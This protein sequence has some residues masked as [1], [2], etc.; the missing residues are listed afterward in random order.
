[1]TESVGQVVVD[2]AAL[3][4]SDPLACFRDRFQLPDKKIYLN[5]NSLG[6][7]PVAAVQ[8]AR[9]TVETQWGD[10]L[11]SSWNRHQWIDLPVS[12][13]EKIAPLLGAGAGQVICCDSI[14]VNL[15]KLLSQCLSLRPGRHVVLS[16]TDNFPTDLYVAQGLSELLGQQRCALRM[17][18]AGQLSAA[19]DKS[20][21]VLLLTQVN[22]RDGSVHDIAELTRAAHAA[23]AL[24]IWD[25]AHSAGVLPLQ[26]DEW[27]VDFAVGCG[28]KYLNGGPGA[29]AF[30]Y[31][32]RRHHDST[33]PFLQGW[34][35]HQAPFTFDP[36]FQAARGVS[37]YLTGTPPI[38]SLAVLDAALELFSGIEMQ[39]VYAKTLGLSRL[40]M[41][42]VSAQPELSGL[43]LL[44]PDVDAR[45]GGQLAYA[46]P[47]AYGICQALAAAGVIADFRSPDVLRLGFSPLFLR[48]SDIAAAVASLHQVIANKTYLD[49]AFQRRNKVT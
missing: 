42:L 48:Y 28:Y 30:I 41:N 27:Q 43:V 29:P 14:S 20:V 3:D 23:G 9:A 15:F 31:A 6:P 16:Q 44:T 38:L 49:P 37:A 25:L 1:M 11:V 17:V 35:G 46:H 2:S 47:H 24:V 39:Q 36:Q 5:G 18:E 19:L 40:F 22:F 34:M 32:S 45:R 8:R 13:G 21:A 26:L 33:R 12:V 10:D 4:A 7:L